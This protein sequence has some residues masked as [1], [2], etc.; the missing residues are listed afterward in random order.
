MVEY[1]I[2]VQNEMEFGDFA[3][4]Y[5]RG[6]LK[7]MEEHKWT[8]KFVKDWV[9]KG[10]EMKENNIELYKKKTPSQEPVIP[11]EREWKRTASSTSEQETAPEE[12]PR[13]KIKKESLS[14]YLFV[15]VGK[16]II[17]HMKTK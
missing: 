17:S 10:V 5:E 3:N 14:Y 7:K 2:E 6:L 11:S 16:S 8:E 4:G 1:L 13:K 9:K 12:Q 15:M